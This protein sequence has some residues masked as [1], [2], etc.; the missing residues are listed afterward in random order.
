MIMNSMWIFS[1]KRALLPAT[2]TF[3][4]GQALGSIPGSVR[5]QTPALCAQ[6]RKPICGILS[7]ELSRGMK[8]TNPDYNSYIASSY[9]KY[10]ESSGARVVPILINQQDEYYENIVN[11]VNG[12]VFPG[13]SA[14]IT[15]SSGYGRA[16][17]K[18]YELI[19]E[20]NNN[21]RTMPL[22]AT[23]LG[24]EMLMLLAGH[25]NEKMEV[26]TS[27]KDSNVA[28]PLNLTAGWNTSRILGEAPDDIITPL[29]T[30][31]IT[32]NFHKFCVTNETFKKLDIY[33]DFNILSTN[34]DTLGDEYI[35]TVEHKRFPI[36]GTQW[37]PEKNQYEWKYSSIPH[38][39]EA[40][41]VAQYFGNFFIDKTRLNH[42]S[43][44]NETEEKAHLI[45]NHPVVDMAPFINPPWNYSSSFHQCYFFY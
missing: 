7:Q 30:M 19:L 15:N 41:R 10:Y 36:W 11:S 27:C 3:L 21:G 38:F 6:P 9:V 28:H 42:N 22:W 34:V 17:R 5:P 13:G 39:P 40:I 24:F 14:S 43:F 18:L 1:L 37:H 4:C 29:I 33:K 12:I 31:K 20:A 45:Y 2:A 23:C 44:V 26:L 32:S 25:T 8:K 16:G 35:S